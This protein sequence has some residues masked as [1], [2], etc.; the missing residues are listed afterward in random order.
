MGQV[1]INGLMTHQGFETQDM[2]TVVIKF[3]SLLS[4]RDF[5]KL[6]MSLIP[7]LKT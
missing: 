5:Q 4:F 3:I 6:W 2:I 7:N 1:G